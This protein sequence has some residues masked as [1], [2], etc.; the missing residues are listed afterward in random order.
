M[1]FSMT[2]FL[3]F[4]QGLSTNFTDFLR[5]IHKTWKIIDMQCDISRFTMTVGT[6][7]KP[8][9]LTYG[10]RLNKAHNQFKSFCHLLHKDAEETLQTKSS[11]RLWQK[12][13]GSSY[14]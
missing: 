7:Y 6:L 5:F 1:T 12:R 10:S 9:K 2:P 4:F 8:Q 14:L 13:T 3:F 11:L